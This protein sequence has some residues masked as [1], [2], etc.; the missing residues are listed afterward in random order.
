M[1]DL[2]FHDKG[3]ILVKRGSEMGGERR[4]GGATVDGN[5]TGV[6]SNV[7]EVLRV[8]AWDYATSVT[9]H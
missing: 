2:V 8:G 3:S 4:E 9:A 5:D 1:W 6:A 7:A